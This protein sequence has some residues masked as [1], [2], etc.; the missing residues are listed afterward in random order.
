MD[1]Y[2]LIYDVRPHAMPYTCTNYEV[3]LERSQIKITKQVVE[4]KMAHKMLTRE[5]KKTILF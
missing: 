1:F 4:K 3:L 5:I 2:N